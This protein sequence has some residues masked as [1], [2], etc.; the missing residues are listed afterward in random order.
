MI[1]NDSQP[2][3]PDVSSVPLTQRKTLKFGRFEVSLTVA[4]IFFAFL[5][6]SGQVGQNVSLPLWIDSTMLPPSVGY[7]N[8]STNHTNSSSGSREYR[9]RVDGFFVYSFGCISFVVIFGTMLLSIRLFQP[10]RLGETERMFP[11]S[12]LFL[13]GFFDALNGVL[14]VFA[15]SGSRTAPYLQA[16]LG[17]FMI[18]L[19]MIFR[20]F[21]IRKVPTL[22][23]F[24]C[25]M[26]VLASLFVCLI[27][28]IFT[29]ID[30][31]ADKSGG[32]SGV[33]GILWPLCF[34]FGFLP[35]A[36]MNV[37]EERGLKMEITSAKSRVNLV[38][39]LF[40]TSVYQLLVA[41]CLFWVDFLPEYGYADNIHHFWDNWSFGFK[42]FFGGAGCNSKCGVRGAMFIVMYTI[43]YIGGGNLMRF[44][45]GATL[46]AIVNAVVTPL[47]FLFWT[48]FRES[49]F[50]FHPAVHITTWFSIGGLVAM[51][52]AIF[53]YNTGPEETERVEVNPERSSLLHH[54]D[55]IN[56]YT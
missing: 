22:R 37:I 23:K 16:I 28:K 31:E 43:S 36:I 48:I 47:G 4:N 20:Y 25:A 53:L 29:S 56:G 3:I 1:A 17:N 32:A 52:P 46:L 34:M 12:Q 26:V 9:P 49:P 40:W 14:V 45:E 44:S 15:S 11:H 2:I 41:L 5:A 51:V 7:T 21:I 33:A 8:H 6:I 42:C 18:P 10:H 39:F 35:A 13:V 27:P 19:T 38:F 54:K 50:G 24:L 30:P 55:A